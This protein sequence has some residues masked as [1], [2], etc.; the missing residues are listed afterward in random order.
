MRREDIVNQLMV[1]ELKT[2]AAKPSSYDPEVLLAM[3]EQVTASV[4]VQ[5]R[6][7]LAAFQRQ[8]AARQELRPEDREEARRDYLRQ[9]IVTEYGNQAQGKPFPERYLQMA[10]AHYRLRIG[11][12]KNDFADLMQKTL[13]HQQNSLE[14]SPWA[15]RRSDPDYRQLADGLAVKLTAA[16]AN[17]SRLQA[18]GP[19]EARTVSVGLRQGLNEVLAS[20]QRNPQGRDM[21]EMVATLVDVDEAKP[22]DVELAQAPAGRR[23]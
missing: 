8:V 4:F 2:V 17:L 18:M 21:V 11:A 1:P 14:A 9:L 6:Q 16:N 5:H 12:L 15:M 7:E 19:A 22:D 13:F 23:R 3:Q 10:D 20:Y